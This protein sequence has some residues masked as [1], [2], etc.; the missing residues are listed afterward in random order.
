MPFSMFSVAACFCFCDHALLGARLEVLH[1]LREL[2]GGH[3]GVGA[4][5][6][7]AQAQGDGVEVDLESMRLR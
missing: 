7:V 3:Q 2:G 5:E 1:R 6:A 4:G